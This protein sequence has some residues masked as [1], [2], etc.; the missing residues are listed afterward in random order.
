MIWSDKQTVDQERQL[1][2]S[3]KRDR[4]RSAQKTDITADSTAIRTP[5]GSIVQHQERYES[6]RHCQKQS[7]P[8]KLPSIPPIND[9]KI[10]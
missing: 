4:D 2:P 10:P 7:T 1:N 5:K 3:P 6:L 9:F 8:L